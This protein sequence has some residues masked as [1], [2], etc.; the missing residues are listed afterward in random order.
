MKKTPTAIGLKSRLENL[1]PELRRSMGPLCIPFPNGWMSRACTLMGRQ[2][3]LPDARKSRLFSIRICCLWNKWVLSP[4]GGVTSGNP[5]PL[6]GGRWPCESRGRPARASTRNRGRIQQERRSIG[7]NR[8]RLRCSPRFWNPVGPQLNTLGR[9]CLAR[10]DE[11]VGGIW[12]I[13]YGRHQIS[14]GGSDTT[15]LRWVSISQ[16]L[17]WDIKR[18]CPPKTGLDAT[19]RLPCRDVFDLSV[20]LVQNS[21]TQTCDN[22]SFELVMRK[23]RADKQVRPRA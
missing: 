23:A 1:G 17:A 7:K 4:L 3:W 5:G 11:S 15:D 19:W 12:S 8:T 2:K 14:H 18:G 16:Q 21:E 13:E 10:R 9:T 6:E 22:A 20:F